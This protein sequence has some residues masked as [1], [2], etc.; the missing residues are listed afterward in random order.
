[1][2]ICL[3]DQY[4]S[5]DD[6]KYY[7]TFSVE[8]FSTAARYNWLGTRKRNDFF[9]QF[10][11][12]EEKEQLISSVRIVKYTSH[13]LVALALNGFSLLEIQYIK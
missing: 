12:A 10:V 5:W 6:L 2:T 13:H 4:I 7:L 1:M 3:F 9:F 11:D 8:C